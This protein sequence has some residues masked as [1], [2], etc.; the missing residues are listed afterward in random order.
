MH[1][2]A[3]SL[4]VCRCFPILI[5][6]FLPTSAERI[7]GRGTGRSVRLLSAIFMPADSHFSFLN[8]YKVLTTSSIN[9]EILSK[10][11]LSDVQLHYLTVGPL[12]FL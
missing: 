5:T 7:H 1:P 9:N 11:F 8:I 2:V 6:T 10:I 12:A 3:P 4:S